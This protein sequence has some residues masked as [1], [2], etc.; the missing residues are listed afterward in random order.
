MKI[1]VAEAARY[2]AASGCAL[3]LDVS[4]LWV[5][6]HFFSWW[7]LA[8]AS[9]SYTAGLIV[10]YMLSIKLVFKHRRLKDSRLEFVS[11]A[12]IGLIGLAINAAVIAFCVAY[13]SVNYLVAKCVAAGFTFAWGFLVRRQLLFVPDPLVS[14]SL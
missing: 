14:K 8:A 1:L 4:M 9:A 10:G 6:V 7:Y 5:L 11:F 13:L 12:A 2:T 3:V